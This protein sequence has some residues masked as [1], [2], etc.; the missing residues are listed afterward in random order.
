MGTKVARTFYVSAGTLPRGQINLIRR[1]CKRLRSG[2]L[3]Y[4][5]SAITRSGFCRGR[6]A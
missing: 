4:A 6:P 5:F 3:S 2:S 1:F